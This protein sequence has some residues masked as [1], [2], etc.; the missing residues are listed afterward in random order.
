[1]DTVTFH[2]QART[3]SSE[4]YRLVQGEQPLGHL[5]LH[6]GRVEAFGTLVLDH[7]LSEEDLNAVIEQINDDLVLSSDVTG[8]DFFVRVYVGQEVA[9]NYTDDLLRDEFVIDGETDF[10]Q[11]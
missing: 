7:E 8:E 5:D 6:Y 2:R 4:Q 9:A 1:M 10:G 11:A 3:P